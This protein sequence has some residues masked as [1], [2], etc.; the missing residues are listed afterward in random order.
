[1]TRRRR[2]ALLGFGEMARLGHLPAWRERPEFEL[3]AVV[4]PNPER[5]ALARQALP[6]ARPCSTLEELWEH[7]PLDFVDIATPPTFH[8]AMARAALDRG[9]AVLCEKPL[10]TNLAEFLV[11]AATSR[12]GGIA[13]HTVHN[14]R[15]SPAQRAVSALL[16]SG[17]IGRVRRA[18][19]R[20][21]REGCAVGSAGD[22]RLLGEVAGGG[23]LTDHGWHAF[24]LVAGWL[25]GPPR[26]VRASAEQRRY[27]HAE[28]EDTSHCVIE[29]PSGTAELH[30][31]WAAS[32]RYTA[33]RIEGERGEIRV[34]QGVLVL[35]DERG[36]MRRPVASLSAGSH[37]PDWFGAVIEEFRSVLEDPTQSNLAQAGW[38]V[39]LLSQA[40]RSIRQGGAR[41]PVSLSLP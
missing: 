39:A 20:V 32:R 33:W 5:L 12:S 14:W 10:T 27:L 38:C 34:E 36:R 9:I 7:G 35:E 17:R 25:G 13:L 30:L 3:V 2:G 28:V 19:I 24:Y 15:H 22:W 29:F 11:L 37:H 40:Y 18:E 23:I 16:Q 1:M 6:H 41:V 31:T 4:D 21:E 8:A 26:F